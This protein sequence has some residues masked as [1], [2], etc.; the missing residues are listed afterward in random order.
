MEREVK[1]STAGAAA[2]EERAEV[3]RVVWKGEVIDFVIRRGSP[4][5]RRTAIRVTREGGVEV[6]LPP[7][8]AGTQAFAAVTSRGDWIVRHLRAA[9]SRPAVR[10]PVYA[11]GEEHLL[12]G[13]RYRLE[14]VLPGWGDAFGA[15]GERAAPGEDGAGRTLRLRVRSADAETVRR[16]LFLWYRDRISRRIA[17]RMDAL[18]PAIPW[19]AATPLWRVR[20]MRRRWGSCTGSGVLTLNTQLVKAPPRC[21]DYVLL[22]EIA[23]LREHNHSKRYYAVLDVLF[24]EWRE[25]RRELEHWAPHLLA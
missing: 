25:V 14:L 12:W 1:G 11:A 15:E 2:R 9:E 21:L 17:E 6:L 7:R 13:E 18:C 3:H 22:H 8:A 4:R 23:H 16:Q 5:R 19:L 24:P 10:P 20:V